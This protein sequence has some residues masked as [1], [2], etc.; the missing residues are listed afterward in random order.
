[1]STDDSATAPPRPPS[2]GPLARLVAFWTQ[3]TQRFA[4]LFFLYLLAIALIY[5]A[6]RIRLAPTLEAMEHFTADVVYTLM[7]AISSEV[8]MNEYKAVF[9]G[10]FVVT[11]IEECT[12]LYEALLLGAAMLA[13][14]TTW[15]K[16]ILGFVIG[17][18]MIYAM[19]II[20]ICALLTVG[21]YFGEY[22]EFL[23]LYFWQVTMVLMVATTWLIWVKWVVRRDYEAPET[24]RGQPD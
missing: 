22:F 14:P 24:A 15:G 19:N 1:M 17:F 12:G 9:F 18:P 13:F 4:L 7:S 23:H 21:R 10:P 3:P 20:R 6:A 8:R 5:P 2:K 16:A 11:I